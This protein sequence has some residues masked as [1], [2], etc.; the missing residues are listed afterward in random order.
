LDNGRDLEPVIATS[1][2]NQNIWFDYL[3]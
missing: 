1:G 2:E 3:T